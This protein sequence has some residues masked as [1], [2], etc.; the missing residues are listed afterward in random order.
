MESPL[1]TLELGSAKSHGGEGS[2]CQMGVAELS[3]SCMHLKLGGFL[4]KNCLWQRE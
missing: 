4:P 3:N 2:S 1:L